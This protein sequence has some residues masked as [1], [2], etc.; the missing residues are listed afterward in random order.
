MQMFEIMVAGHFSVAGDMTLFPQMK[1]ALLQHQYLEVWNQMKGKLLRLVAYLTSIM[2]LLNS[3][4]TCT[5]HLGMLVLEC[6]GLEQEMAIVHF[7]HNSKAFV[8]LGARELGR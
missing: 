3:C 5:E 2:V 4:L 1:R 7:Q 6:S 8:I